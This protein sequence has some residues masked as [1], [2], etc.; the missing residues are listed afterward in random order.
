[1]QR[2][3][4]LERR[5]IPSP[6]GQ[7]PKHQTII[8]HVQS[9]SSDELRFL[10]NRT[11]VGSGRS[12]LPPKGLLE[13]LMERALVVHTWHKNTQIKWKI[14]LHQEIFEDDQGDWG[15]NTITVTKK[16][17]EHGPMGAMLVSRI[18]RIDE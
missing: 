16:L 1:M 7:A 5:H 12:L 2:T 4:S 18:G 3:F 13:T 11:G 9:V 10:S 6:Q 17:F 8:S 14:D 15:R